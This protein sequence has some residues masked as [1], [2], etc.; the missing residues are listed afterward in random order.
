MYWFRQL[1]KVTVKNKYPFLRIDD[2]FDQMRREKAFSKNELRYGYQH[3]RIKDEDVH[4][5][6]FRER[7]GSY[8]L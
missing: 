2:P 6:T 8:E 1:N 5:T 7:F 4:Q 3:V